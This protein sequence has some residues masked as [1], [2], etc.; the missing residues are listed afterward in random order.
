MELKEV[1]FDLCAAHGVSGSERSAFAV[2][3]RYLAPFARSIYSD[4]NG[5]LYAELGDPQAAKTLLLDAHLDRIGLIVTD[6]DDNGFVKVDKCGGVDIRTLQNTVIES[7]T[8]LRG[9]VCCLPPHLSDGSEDKANPI[10]KTWLDFGMP[11]EEVKKRLSVGDVLTFCTEP[12]ELLGGKLTAPALDN[13]S[14]VAS[15][16]RVAELLSGKSCPYRVTLLLSS[17]EETFGT[18][19]ATGAFRIDADEAIAVDVSFANQPDISG[20]YAG[21]SLKKGPM[22]GIAPILS[23]QMSNRLIAL[24]KERNI[25]FQRE[26]LAGRTGTNADRIALTKSGVRTA[27]VSIPEKYMHTQSEVIHPDDV[28]NTAQLIAAYILSGGA[29]DD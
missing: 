18:G 1:L 5:N 21:I 9:T 11:A 28:E 26:P 19:A 23:R 16:I 27:L 22:I 8:G 13:R 4:A 10:S 3:R 29:F 17:Q 20:Q 12:A 2:A 6:I 15:L 14:G 24:A 7:E 25:P